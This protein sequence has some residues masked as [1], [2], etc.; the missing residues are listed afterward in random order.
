MPAEDPPAPVFRKDIVEFL[1]LEE[2]R[3]TLE[4][5]ARQLGKQSGEIA[6]RLLAYARAHGGKGQSIVRSGYVLAVVIGRGSV[7]WKQE[8]VRVAG[9]DAAEALIAAAP[10][11]EKLSVEA[12]A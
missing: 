10:P 12:A 7:P 2:R 8:F 3:K 6:D 1:D 5:E 4:R 9:L 11:V